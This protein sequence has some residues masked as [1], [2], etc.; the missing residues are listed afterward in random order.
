MHIQSDTGDKLLIL[1]QSSY[2]NVSK[3]PLCNLNL[4][5]IF[6]LLWKMLLVTVWCNSVS[7]VTKLWADN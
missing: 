5:V 7:I 6:L 1:D 2:C 3:A 4:T